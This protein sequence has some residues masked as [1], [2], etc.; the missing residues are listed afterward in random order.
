[1]RTCYGRTKMRRRGGEDKN[2]NTEEDVLDEDIV[3]V[4]FLGR[5]KLFIVVFLSV[6][7]RRAY[8][9]NSYQMHNRFIISDIC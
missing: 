1:M 3:A 6:V 8:G 4:L 2:L 5:K 9:S 7:V